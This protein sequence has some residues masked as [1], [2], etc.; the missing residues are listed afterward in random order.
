MVASVALYSTCCMD[1]AF[2]FDALVK[3]RP[4]IRILLAM[5]CTTMWIYYSLRAVLLSSTAGYSGVVQTVPLVR[6]IT[7]VRMMKD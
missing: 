3:E 4:Y 5:T 7:P 6:M 2:T 1:D